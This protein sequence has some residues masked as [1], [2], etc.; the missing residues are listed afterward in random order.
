MRKMSETKQTTEERLDQLEQSHYELTELVHGGFISVKAMLA[1][2]KEDHYNK[3]EE[4]TEDDLDQIVGEIQDTI[5][6]IDTLMNPE[7][8]E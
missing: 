1:K 5:D 7:E 8:E 6:W 4:G 2:I 3:P